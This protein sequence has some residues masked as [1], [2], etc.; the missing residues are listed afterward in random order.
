MAL[1]LV[2]VARF[3]PHATCIY[4]RGPTVLYREGDTYDGIRRG[5]IG[6]AVELPLFTFFAEGSSLI[7]YG[8]D[9]NMLDW[10]LW[11]NYAQVRA[12]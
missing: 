10:D 11:N 3:P 1:L 9:K 2:A 5:R 8:A 6:T 12:H 4:R 7:L